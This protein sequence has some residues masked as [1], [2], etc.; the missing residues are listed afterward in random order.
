MIAIIT[1]S[2]IIYVL[3][4]VLAIDIMCNN[5]ISPDFYP[6][7]VVFTPIL[8]TIFCIWYGIRHTDELREIFKKLK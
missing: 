7:V 3:S 2:V 5:E 4:L 1:S 6:S 8:N